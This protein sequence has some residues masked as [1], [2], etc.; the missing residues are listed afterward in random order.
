[1]WD[2]DRLAQEWDAHRTQVLRTDYDES[3]S[4]TIELSLT[5][6]MFRKLGPDARDLLGVVAF[7]PQGINE[8]NLDWLFP[9]IADRKNMFDKL[10]AL[11]LTYRSNGF[12][13][14][15]APLRD[16]FCPTDP[17]SSPLLQTTKEYYFTRLS[18][19][20]DPGNPGFEE[21]RWITSED[22]NVEHLLNA[23]TLIDAN[24]VDVWN[25][26]AGFMGHMYWH[27]PRL[28]VLGPRIEGLPDDHPSKALCL[29]RLSRLCHMVGNETERKRLLIH[30]LQLWRAEG[31][32]VRVAQTLRGLSEANMMLGLCKEGI[33]RAKE[34]SEI[35]KRLDDRLGQ[36][37]S[38]CSLARLLH[39]A[40]QL[41]AAEEAALQ[42]IDLLPNEDEQ[43]RASQYHRLLGDIYRSK[44]ET[45]EAIKYLEKAL[46]IA[47]P[48][49]WRSE[50]FWIHH[51]LAESFFGDNRFDDAH[52]H[53]EHAKMQ[54]IDDP[55]KLGRVMWLQA[56][57]WFTEGR[58]EEAKSG[59]LRAA[60]AYEKVGC[61]EGLENCERGLQKI[62]ARMGKLVTSG[63][64]DLDGESLETVPLP[65]PVDS[66]PSSRSDDRLPPDINLP[67]PLD[68]YPLTAHSRLLHSSLRHCYCYPSLPP[69]PLPNMFTP[70]T[71]ALFCIGYPPTRPLGLTLV[72]CDEFTSHQC[73]CGLSITFDGL[74]Y[75]GRGQPKKPELERFIRAHLVKCGT[76]VVDSE[77]LHVRPNRRTRLLT[78]PEYW[79]MLRFGSPLQLSA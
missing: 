63:E 11:S 20:V 52:T 29:Y 25:A 53:I 44:G 12:V 47:S 43:F 18:V 24:S 13:T 22:T 34:A 54:A 61:M 35:Y 31:D 6:P 45:G 55:Y 8:N 26:C 36:S 79:A 64:S 59:L 65:T 73:I 72:S 78:T 70:C 15:L 58:F 40:K 62:E 4:A 27:K 2:Y 28:V 66:V 1:M 75:K 21:A 37:F 42:A 60:D 33:E 5:S 14:M 57:F 46:E 17:M 16:H 38:F 23:F 49:N 51:S 41:D 74:V 9:A 76:L 77:V 39:D 19:R 10:C 7:F 67:T 71:C 32:D 69:T 3:L 48:F 56:N 30:C 68:E 50:L